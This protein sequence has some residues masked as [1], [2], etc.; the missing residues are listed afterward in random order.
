[1]RGVWKAVRSKTEEQPLLLP[2]VLQK[3]VLAMSL[4]EYENSVLTTIAKKCART[5]WCEPPREDAV[6]TALRHLSAHKM[7]TR[8]Y[9]AWWLV[10]PTEKAMVHIASR[11][12]VRRQVYRTT[13][14]THTAA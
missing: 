4:T 3:S 9:E 12:K 14:F 5:H 13:K 10:R 6:A 8:K 7:I 11:K 2:R 1:M